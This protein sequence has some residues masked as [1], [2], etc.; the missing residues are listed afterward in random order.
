MNKIRKIVNL[1]NVKQTGKNIR[2][3]V[4]D[5]GIFPHIDLRNNIILQKDYINNKVEKYDDNG[6]GTHISGIISG[7]GEV[8]KGKYRG[9]ACDAELISLKVL[10]KN[11]SGKTSDF[12]SALKWILNNKENY[13]IKILNFSVGFLKNSNKIDQIRIIELIDAIWDAGIIVVSAAGNNGPGKNSVT[14]PGISRKIITVGANGE[15]FSGVGPTDCCIVKP[16]IL[17]PGRNIVSTKNS[18]SDYIT[19]T[20]TSMAT[21]IVSGAIALALE[22]NPSLSP[23]EIKICLY[24]TVVKK[25]DSI[26]WGELDIKK[27]IDY[28]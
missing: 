9:I 14:V 17:A 23:S 3:A 22:K 12:I 6:H 28:V 16:E 24:H 4:L 25:E 8:L 27:L 11:G 18:L 19:K 26:S 7:S 15:V 1:S 2:I 13:N 21:P 20:G 5:T 10:D